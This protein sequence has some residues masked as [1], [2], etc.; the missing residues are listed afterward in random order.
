M[1]APEICIRNL[2]KGDTFSRI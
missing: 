1:L 2:H